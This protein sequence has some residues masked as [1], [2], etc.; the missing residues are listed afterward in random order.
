MENYLDITRSV[1]IS[2]PAGSG[3]TEKLA[4]RYVSLLL[5]GSEIEKILA[6]TFTE[7]AAAEMKDRILT[8]LEKEDPDLFLKVREKMPLMRISTIHAFCLKLLKRF[9]IELG[10][11]PSLDVMDEFSAS[12]L[13]SESVYECLIEEKNSPDLFF[14]MMKNRGIKGWDGL[15]RL[16]NELHSRRPHSE[17]FLR[18]NHPVEEEGEKRILEL[19]SRCLKRYTDKKLE[20]HL[21][22]FDDLE[23]LTYGALIKNPEWQNILYSFDEH[24]DHILVDEFQDTSS[25]QW[26]IIDKFTE[27]W[28]SGIGAKKDSGKIPT[29]FLVGDEKQSIYLFRGANVSVFQEAKER[30]S[31]WLGREYYFEEIRENY[32]SLPE[33]T[34]FVNSL[35]E[36]LMHPDPELDSGYESWRTRYAPFEATRQGDGRVELILMEGGEGTKKSREQEASVLSKRIQSLVNHYEIFDGDMKRPCIYGDMAILLRRRTHLS[37]FEDALRRH[38]IPFIVVKGIGF[39]DEPEVALLRELLSLIIDPMDDYSLFCILRSPLFGIDYRTLFRLIDK[40]GD[41]SLLE[42]IRSTKNK[43]VGEASNL[44]LGWIE[45]SRYTPLAMVL[46]D[47]LS[48]TGGWQYYWEKQRHANAKKFIRLIEQYESQG[49][50]T[51][52]IREKLIKARQG[53]E[54]KAN[55]NTEGMNA[56]KIMTIHAAK[57]LQFPMV[58]LPSLDEDNSPRTKSIVIDEEGGRI[59]IAYEEDPAKRKKMESFL[60]R[61]EKELEEEKRL[62]YVAVTRAQ[63]FLCMLGA[64]KKEKKVSGR[65]AYIIDI[66]EHLSSLKIMNESQIDEI[67]L[68]RHSSLST[69]QLPSEP[70]MSEPIYTEPISYEPPFKWRDITE[71]IDIR[72]RHGEE[73]VLL[74]KVF[75]KLFEELSKGHIGID[76]IEKRALILLRAEIY[77]K[78]EVER[79]TEII[80]RDFER[81]SVSGYLKD[82][83]FPLRDSHTE[84]PFNLPKGKTIFRGRI[85]RIIVKDNIAHIYDYKT[86]PTGEKGLSELIDKY[87]FQMDIYREAVE[88]TFFLRTKGYLLFTHMPLLVEV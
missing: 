56:V 57:G 52:D 61:K 87:R 25:L 72:V 74:G 35:F 34:K 59:S 38:G 27:E 76:D 55:I 29:I 82:I 13:W 11:D 66:L 1:I 6:V 3:K 20:R 9:S 64:W 54:A 49:F 37:I 4:R 45:R 36:G 58:F 71:E 2:S 75:H 46:E 79:M 15:F 70:F 8:I 41:R 80:K 31:E 83:V 18:E 81:L 47:V 63:D 50:S 65:L 26:K 22:D 60:K 77:N 73:W 30:F 53:D 48:E 17:L 88:K 14:E 62:F 86:F 78:K 32:R 23:L 33:I 21:I 51:L 68:T 69:H 28:R 84:L 39:Y 10:L 67:Y 24:T 44:I 19:Y 85:D 16:L 43:K 12:L 5:G 7:K 40:T 42:E